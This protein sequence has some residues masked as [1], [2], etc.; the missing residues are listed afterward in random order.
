MVVPSWPVN[1]PGMVTDEEHSGFRKGLSWLF[2]DCTIKGSTY[3]TLVQ[4]LGSSAVKA[5]IV[6]L[7]RAREIT[8]SALGQIGRMRWKEYV[9]T[10]SL[11][12]CVEP[13]AKTKRELSKICLKDFM[14]KRPITSL[15]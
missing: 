11:I 1:P 10:A 13:I 14:V 9:A 5:H 6:N 12:G 8:T 15:E 4:L 7:H 2:F 3:A